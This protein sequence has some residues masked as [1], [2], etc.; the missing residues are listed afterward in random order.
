[1]LYTFTLGGASSAYEL[2]VIVLRF[3]I[4]FAVALSVLVSVDRLLH[5]LKCLQARTSPIM[6]AELIPNLHEAAWQQI[7][8]FTLPRKA[9][10]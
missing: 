2:Y 7:P 3:A 9:R 5:V 4:A 8:C 6:P 10:M 1:M